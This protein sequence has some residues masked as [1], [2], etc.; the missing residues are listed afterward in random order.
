MV[1]ALS[2]LQVRSL[3][4]QLRHVNR[5]LDEVGLVG[6]DLNPR[7]LRLPYDRVVVV[8]QRVEPF[9][10]GQRDERD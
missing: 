3:V 6:L 2:E 7:E 5:A 4:L 8:A 9:V 10:V 1:P